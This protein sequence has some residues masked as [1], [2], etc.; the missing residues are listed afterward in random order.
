MLRKNLILSCLLILSML[1]SVGCQNA[2]ASNEENGVSIEDGPKYYFPHEGVEHE[3]TWLQWPHNNT[4]KGARGAYEEIWIEMTRG[5]VKGE[6]VH[7]IVYDENEKEHVKNILEEENIDMSKVDFYVFP[8]DDVWVRDNGPIFVYDEEGNLVIENWEFNGWGNKA[9]YNKDNQI[10]TKVSDAIGIP[11]IDIDMVMEGGA[12]ELD[13]NGTV[14]S[15]LSC[16]N[17]DNRTKNFTIEEI[18][19]YLT[20]YYGVT[21][22]IWL[23]GVAGMDI[24]DNHIDG[25]IK[26]FDDKTIIA[27]SEFDLDPSDLSDDDDAKKLLTAK[28]INGEPYEFVFLP[29]TKENVVE[30][31]GEW[32]KGAYLNFYVG[33]KVV[34]VPNYDDENDEVANKILQ[35]LY[36]DKEVIGIDVRDLYADG[37]MIHCV[38]QQQPIAKLK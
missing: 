34:L 17:N 20:K 24:T 19:A 35:D 36:T 9:P 21:N 5:L 16:V 11:K 38:T 23:D 1:L 15:T 14:I 37:G 22:F 18:E 6:N 3:G 25:M 4:Y 27:A 10:P 2:S 13:G 7:L 8:T 29:E 28:N 26:F 32:I 12:L 33:N 30:V 31:D